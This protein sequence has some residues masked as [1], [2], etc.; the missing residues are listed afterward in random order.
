MAAML[1]VSTIDLRSD[2]FNTVMERCN[3]L[4]TESEIRDCIR[5]VVYEL[6]YLPEE[7]DTLVD[8]YYPVVSHRVLYSGIV[9]EKKISEGSYGEVYVGKTS[10]G[11]V[12]IKVMK[13][14]NEDTIPEFTGLTTIQGPHIIPLLSVA[15]KK[16]ILP[17][18]DCTLDSYVKSDR[19]DGS[20]ESIRALMYKLLVGMLQFEMTKSMH[21]DIKPDNILMK[22]D[23]PWITDLGLGRFHTLRGLKYASRVQTLWWRAPE[24][25]LSDLRNV[26]YYTSAIDVWSMG[27][28][29]ADICR[30][31]AGREFIF[32]A[33]DEK[34]YRDMLLKYIGVPRNSHD[35]SYFN[36]DGTLKMG[37]E[38]ITISPPVEGEGREK[39]LKERLSQCTTLPPEFKDMII[40]MLELEPTKRPTFSELLR[41]P[42]FSMYPKP[43]YMP[44]EFYFENKNNM[45]YSNFKEFSFE[46][47]DIERNHFKIVYQ[48]LSEV[49]DKFRILNSLCQAYAIMNRVLC[50]LPPHK[51]TR[52]TLQGYGVMALHLGEIGLFDA[53]TSIEDM[54]H[55]TARAYSKEQLETMRD[56]MLD[57][58]NY[59]ICDPIA[60]HYISH[61]KRELSENEFYAYSLISMICYYSI[62]CFEDSIFANA[63]H[64][65][66]ANAI[67]NRDDVI[68]KYINI[69]LNDYR[70][71]AS[72]KDSKWETKSVLRSL[73]RIQDILE[74]YLIT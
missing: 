37:Y 2:V 8:Q 53:S 29:F 44:Y 22:G 62:A 41:N 45:L 18:A 65:E 55:I 21:R 54:V 39:F 47:R 67:L 66:I 69:F 23:Y 68:F 27:M 71:T 34:E 4:T 14:F 52:R 56:E 46:K 36:E 6:G 17:L 72:E 57:V 16:L 70:N 40:S 15:D 12:A 31:K 25:A 59:R 43:I 7:I 5:T 74:P 49:A 61:A 20:V 64:I 24:I 33:S 32:R 50:M 13:K 26:I 9:H 3:S 51:I 10:G 28:T 11:D 19:F 48:W 38:W 35:V 58:L 60:I 42:I 63:S 1:R 73:K 30:L